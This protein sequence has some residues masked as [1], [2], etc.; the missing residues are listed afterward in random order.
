[1]TLA[2][3][4]DGR[5]VVSAG[6]NS[7]ARLWDTSRRAEG[8]DFL[9]LQRPPHGEDIGN[10]RFSSDGTSLI[11]VQTTKGNVGVARWDIASGVFRERRTLAITDLPNFPRSDI[12]LTADGTRV[13]ALKASDVRSATLWD[14]ATGTELFTLPQQGRTISAVA[15]TP[16]GSLLVT[17]ARQQGQDPIA[18][19]IVWDGAAGSE[20]RRFSV[21]AQR[22]NTLAISSDG[23]RLAAAAQQPIEKPAPVD[24]LAPVV[25]QIWDLSDG[26]ELGH[27]E[28]VKGLV[29]GMSFNADGTIL[30]WTASQVGIVAVWEIAAKR[31]RFPPVAHI[32]PTNVGFSP[33]GRRLV[34]TGYDGLVRMW[35]ADTGSNVLTLRGFGPPAGGGN[36]FSPRVV[37][38]PDGTRLAANNWDGT[39]SVWDAGPRTDQGNAP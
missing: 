3:S 18:D 12:A 10:L 33:D 25:I 14:A 13:L 37:F 36:G 16:D 21:G 34:A 9:P 6:E 38:S 19:V 39:V 17:A 35:D 24:G 2:F 22:I 27:I 5:R 32:M 11:I 1:L 8:F 4:S 20:R 28:D 7:R 30:A 29:A 15:M 23:R 31:L 26:R